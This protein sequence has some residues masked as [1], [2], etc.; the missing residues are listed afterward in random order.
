MDLGAELTRI[1][2]DA[3]D[4]LS[5]ART[6]PSENAHICSLNHN[7]IT[8]STF[9]AWALRGF[10][11]GDEYGLSNAVIYAKRAACCRIDRL[12]RNYH[13]RLYCRTPFPAKI[14]A[15]KELGLVVPNVIQELVIDPR[16]DLEHDYVFADTGTARRAVDIA[17]LFLAATDS[18][19]SY[20]SIIALNMNMHYSCIGGVRNEVTFSG[21]SKGAMLFMDVFSEPHT[22]MIVDGE[23]GEVLYTELTKFTRQQAVQLARILHAHFTQQSRGSRWNGTYFFTEIKRLAR[24]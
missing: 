22:A 18:V 11:E 15:L 13:L 19:D 20:G 14:E 23:R 2:T 21:W 6:I 12:I 4:F 16:N 9:L 7:T 1:E 24:F 8:P 3:E 5:G 10:G 17:T